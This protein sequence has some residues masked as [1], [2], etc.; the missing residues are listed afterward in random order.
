MVAEVTPN[1]PLLLQTGHLSIS[2]CTC[3]RTGSL[4]VC[5]G[6]GGE[7]VPISWESQEWAGCTG[8]YW[9]QSEHHSSDL[10]KYNKHFSPE[11]V[12]PLL[13]GWAF[14]CV[15]RGAIYGLANKVL[16]ERNLKDVLGWIQGGYFKRLNCT[17]TLHLLAH[18]TSMLPGRD[19]HPGARWR[20]TLWPWESH[21]LCVLALALENKK[22][23]VDLLT[24][25]EGKEVQDGKV[26]CGWS[27]G[28]LMLTSLFSTCSWLG[29]LRPWSWQSYRK[30]AW[31]LF[32]LK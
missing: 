1:V 18:I 12:L 6:S 15:W 26:C 8:I 20:L 23:H 17:L 21:F 27:R 31:P 24:N 19:G 2:I 4:L 7:N 5:S 22:A 25:M 29:V 32:F 30:N 11:T 9:D 14:I 28:P 10:C 16:E 13:L 3:W